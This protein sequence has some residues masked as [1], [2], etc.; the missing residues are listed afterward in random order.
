MRLLDKVILVTGSVTG[1][2]EG[3]AR[4]FAAEGARVVVHGPEEGA[5]AR[6]AESLGGAATWVAGDLADAAVPGRLI[7]EAAQANGGRLHALVN[8]AALT[9][10]SNLDTTDAAFFDRLIAVNL[11]A[12]LLLI[13]AALPIFRAQGGGKVLN[14]GSTNA[15][16]GER[17][18]LDYSISKGG[19]M[20][21]TRNLA[22]AHAHEGIRVC[23]L[24]LGWTLT[25]NEYAVKVRDGLPP[26]WPDRLPP[27]K[28]P[29]GR[30][31]SPDD[32]AAAAVYLLS[33]EAPLLNG[34]VIDF[35]Q[36]PVMGRNPTP[37]PQR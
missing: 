9:T 24:N 23:Q 4:R 3:M 30:L 35:E 27:E 10:R 16:C 11:R 37:L 36:Y 15:Y 21:L 7:A 26:D 32:V 2:G 18:L 13:Q 31:L 12:P 5:A 34:A 25:P 17:N 14:I 1:V 22:D 8:N 33:D 29:S 20:T 28:A 19:L 6:M